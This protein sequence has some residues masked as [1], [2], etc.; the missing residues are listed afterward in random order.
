MLREVADATMK[1]LMVELDQQQETYS[2]TKKLF[3]RG[4]VPKSELMKDRAA[5]MRTESNISLLG[6][7]LDNK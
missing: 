4:F 2:Y 1:S 3:D 7:I 6:R 5:L